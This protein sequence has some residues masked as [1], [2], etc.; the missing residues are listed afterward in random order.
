MVETLLLMIM[1]EVVV[2]VV[3]EQARYRSTYTIS[4]NRNC[5]GGSWF[6][7]FNNWFISLQEVVAEAV[8]QE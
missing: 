2:V 3:L 1:Q 4:A 8:V 5:N 6:S 7:F